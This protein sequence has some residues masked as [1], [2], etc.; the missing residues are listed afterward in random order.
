MTDF[1]KEM[2]TRNWAF[3]TPKEQEKIKNTTI[4][5]AGCGLGS[6][7]A[8]L[9][10]ETGFTKFILVDYDDVEISN[11]NRQVFG[12]QHIGKNKAI[13]LKSILEEKS[14]VVEVE[15]YPEKITPDNIEKF[16]DKADIIIN[17]VDFDETTYEINRISSEKAK[18]VFFPM[19]MGWGGFCMIFTNESK[20]LEQIIGS[21]VINNDAEFI[22][23]LITGSRGLKLPQYLS[24]RL[25]EMGNIINSN[26]M[27]A[28]QLAVAAVRSA[29]IV[30]EEMVK[31]IMGVSIRV[32]PYAITIDTFETCKE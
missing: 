7:I 23:K 27:G 1:Y 5:L 11:L 9:A 16:V 30:I 28:P 21:K 29:S 31:L 12:Q 13:C 6:N 22:Q 32:S 26:D 2:M 18:P 24:S 25:H 4:L 8:F 19:N 20:S 14:K 3:I 17:T 10:V 15:A